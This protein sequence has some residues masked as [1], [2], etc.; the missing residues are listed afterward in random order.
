MNV[1]ADPLCG[2]ELESREG[3]WT[4]PPRSPVPP[5]AAVYGL[6]STRAFR[7]R[8]EVPLRAI[9]I[10]L[11]SRFVHHHSCLPWKRYHLYCQSCSLR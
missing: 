1:E 2:S 10:L 3:P 8:M 7:V 11:I 9:N 5:K 4:A 6:A